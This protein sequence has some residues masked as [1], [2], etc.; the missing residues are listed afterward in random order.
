MGCNGG[1]YFPHCRL[2]FAFT[3][4]SVQLY[5]SYGTLQLC[6]NSLLMCAFLL[7]DSKTVAALCDTANTAALCDTAAAAAANGQVSEE[8]S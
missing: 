8:L 3:H 2:T 1:W 7:N 5:H 4:T 6:D